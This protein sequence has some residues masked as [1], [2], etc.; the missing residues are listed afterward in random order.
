MINIDLLPIEFAIEQQR[1][2]RFTLVQ[3]ISTF[4]ILFFIFLASLTLALRIL[5][6]QNFK[7]LEGQNEELKEK[8]SS[9]QEREEAV[10]ILKNRLSGIA[11]IKLSPSK[12]AAVYKFINGLFTNSVKAS[13]LTVDRGGN[14]VLSILASDE[15][16]LDKFLTGLQTD[17]FEQFSKIEIESLSRGKEETLRANLKMLAK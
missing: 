5:Q 8:V 6:S 2:N 14:A 11:Q 4:F 3:T 15:D 7:N 1:K 17:G 13:S 9:F 12:Q 16:S 10:V